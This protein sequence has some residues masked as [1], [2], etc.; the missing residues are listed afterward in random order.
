MIA[1]DEVAGVRR[2]VFVPEEWE[3]QQR[4]AETRNLIVRIVIGVVFGG[5]LVSA[6]VLGVVAWSRGATRRGCSSPR[7]GSCS[8]SRS[9]RRSTRGR[10]RRRDMPTEIP[11]PLQILG[12]IGV[13]LVALVI[14]SSL[15][16]L[17]LGAQPARLDA[18]GSLAD[19]RRAA[20]R[21]CGRRIRRGAAGARR[22]A[23]DAGLGGRRR[24]SRRSERSCRRLRSP[25]IR[26][27]AS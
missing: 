1:G 15:A 2:F 16:G 22:V 13:G 5:L 8:S 25:S 24:T 19:A 14:T 27:P 23:P 7:P 26:S 3:R 9:R 18:S 4:A 10:R 17:A 11:L 6:A 21:G 20:A 12:A